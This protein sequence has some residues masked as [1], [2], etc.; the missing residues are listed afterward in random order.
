MRIVENTSA[1][2]VLRDRSLWLTYVFGA[3]AIFLSVG[4]LVVGRL[5]ALALAALFSLFA[6]LSLRSSD[7][8]LDKARKTCTIKRRDV[9]RATEKQLAFREIRSV[10]VDPMPM[11]S[12][13]ASI[14]CRLS[15]DTDQG[16]F[17][18]TTAYEPDLDHYTAMRQTILDTVQPGVHRPNDDDPVDRLVAAGRIIDAVTLLRRR[19]KL[20]VTEAR[21]KVA[22]L[23][24]SAQ[25]RN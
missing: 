9:W 10:V 24:A 12:D 1:R 25:S 13:A 17:P 16:T 4:G 22:E 14:S 23:Q 20:G 2:L 8:V 5:N 18:L 6:L 3:A 15:F 21:A 19:D 7:V 11:Q